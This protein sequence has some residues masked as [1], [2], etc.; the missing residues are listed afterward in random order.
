MTVVISRGYA[1]VADRDG[2]A[3]AQPSRGKPRL[4]LCRI[5]AVDPRFAQ[6]AV[7]RCPLCTEVAD[8]HS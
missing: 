4:T 5:T 3:H 8:G 2:I 7:V 1:W 6:P